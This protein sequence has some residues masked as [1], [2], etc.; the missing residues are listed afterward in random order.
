MASAEQRGFVQAY[1]HHRG[2]A[3]VEQPRSERRH[4]QRTDDIHGHERDGQRQEPTV[5][6]HESVLAARV[7]KDMR[8]A[9][10]VKSLDLSV[11]DFRQFGTASMVT[12]T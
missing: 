11:F 12:R 6:F 4:K 10:Y 3:L 7:A 9:I 2:G 8:D 1:V 5:R